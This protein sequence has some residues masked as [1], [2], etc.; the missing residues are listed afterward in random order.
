[1]AFSKF[2]E[3]ESNKLQYQI[4]HNLVLGFLCKVMPPHA[5]AYTTSALCSHDYH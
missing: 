2:Y 1:M 4:C 3:F 5:S